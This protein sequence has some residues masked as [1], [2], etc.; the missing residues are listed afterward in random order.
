MA[1]ATS[2]AAVAALDSKIACEAVGTAAFPAIP[3]CEYSPK[4]S[5]RSGCCEWRPVARTNPNEDGTCLF[6]EK[7]SKQMDDNAAKTARGGADATCV[8]EAGYPLC[9]EQSCVAG[10]CAQTAAVVC[11]D[12]IT[13]GC[14]SD[15]GGFEDA[16]VALTDSAACLAMDADDNA[17][18]LDCAFTSTF[19]AS[20]GPVWR[21]DTS[22]VAGHY[23]TP[24]A[25]D[26]FM[27]KVIDATAL[28]DGKFYSITTRGTTQWTTCGAANNDTVFKA[29]GCMGTGTA[30][31]AWSGGLELTWSFGSNRASRCRRAR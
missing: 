17:D 25:G 24:T 31:D 14:Q 12:A 6:Y 20:R 16:C 7:G 22:L 3:A 27:A 1:D 10:T 28:V 15:G 30:T 4:I 23:Y 21:T 2:C 29:S 13:A 9:D 5:D 26:T 19:V 18:T 11:E 8:G